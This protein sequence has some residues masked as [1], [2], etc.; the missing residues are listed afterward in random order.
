MRIL[1]L[2]LLLMTSFVFAQE[3]SIDLC[4]SSTKSSCFIK[5][6]SIFYVN[7][8]IDD[9]AN[10]S[11]CKSQYPNTAYFD[12]ST[13]FCMSSDNRQLG[14]L[15][16]FEIIYDDKPT[17]KFFCSIDKPTFPELKKCLK[18]DDASN[19]CTDNLIDR[20]V[21]AASKKWSD[22][23]CGHKFVGNTYAFTCSGVFPNGDM[24]YGNVG[25][26][27][28][29]NYEDQE[30]ENQEEPEPPEEPKKPD[31]PCFTNLEN[32]DVPPELLPPKDPVNPDGPKW[33][34]DNVGDGSGNGIGNGNGSENGT[35]NGNE[36]GS[37]NGIGN[38]N[39]DKDDLTCKGT[40]CTGSNVDVGSLPSGS[41]TDLYQPK[42]DDNFADF[43][44]T[45]IPDVNTTK[46][47]K[48]LNKLVPVLPVGSCPSFQIKG[49][50]MMGMI[51]MQDQDVSI[52]CWIYDLIRAFLQISAVVYARKII[53]G[54]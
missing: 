48:E 12:R 11:V 28:Q 54:A 49:F 30:C 33:P 50:S 18:L 8:G 45:N 25:G 44:L 42:N 47:G 35:G 17:N 36:D 23:R 31:V 51:L 41:A 40:N 3:C 16:R 26:T 4:T 10:L 20:T 22:Y 43:L 19:K 6:D 9:Y 1:T 39:Y 38:G 5:D 13:S 37:G 32:C 27:C 7:S 14:H 24:S 46:V 15:S 53:F 29:I 2:F 21:D 52:P 34:T